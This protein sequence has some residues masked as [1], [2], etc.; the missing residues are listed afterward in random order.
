VIYLD[1][2]AV[3]WLY[4]KDRDR[5]TPA[6][7]DLLEKEDLLVSPVV[8]LEMEFLFEI[9]RI[10]ERGDVILS[11]LEDRIGLRRCQESFSRIVGKAV[12]MKW[13]R[14]PFDRIITAQAALQDARLLTRDKLIRKNYP[15]AIW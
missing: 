8:E 6:S 13:T 12:S 10:V 3:V 1:T 9:E 2:H 15:K 11:Y 14:D 7:L 5:F 4:Q